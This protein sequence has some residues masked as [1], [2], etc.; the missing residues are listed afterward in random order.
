MGASEQMNLA[1][2]RDMKNHSKE[3]N[4]IFNESLGLLL[5]II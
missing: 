2:H 1:A 5:V 3:Y 4:P